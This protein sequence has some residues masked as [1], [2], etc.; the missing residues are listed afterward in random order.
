MFGAALTVRSLLLPLPHVWIRFVLLGR[1]FDIFLQFLILV[2]A[3][4]W[5]DLVMVGMHAHAA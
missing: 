2:G 3:A 1:T 5:F 4:V